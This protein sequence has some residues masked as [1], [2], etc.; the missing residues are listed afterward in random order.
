MRALLIIRDTIR[1]LL[2]LVIVFGVIL[3]TAYGVALLMG[4]PPLGGGELLLAI[5]AMYPGYLIL[6]NVPP[7]GWIVEKLVGSLLE[8]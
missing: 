2:A 8:D 5:A 1:Y 6:E 7:F 3:G 4:G